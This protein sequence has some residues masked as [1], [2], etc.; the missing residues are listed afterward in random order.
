MP[1]ETKKASRACPNGWTGINKLAGTVFTVPVVLCGF[2]CRP[3]FGLVGEHL[4][5][6]RSA[7]L[8]SSLV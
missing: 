4:F 2:V 6:I 5:R 8:Y 3:D 1:S 7:V